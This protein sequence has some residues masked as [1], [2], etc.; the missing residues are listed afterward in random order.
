MQE[1]SIRWKQPAVPRH[2]VQAFIVD[3]NENLLLM[4]R[5][6]KVKSAKNVWSIP[7]GTHE[8]GESAPACL[9]REIKEEFDLEVKYTYLIDQ[10]ENIAGDISW[11]PFNDSDKQATDFLHV[12]VKEDP[13]HSTNEYKYGK[14]LYRQTE[15][16]WGITFNNAEDVTLHTIDNF[17]VQNE[18]YHWVLSLF[19]C[20]VPDVN[21]FT[22]MEPELHDIV[23]IISVGDLTSPTFRTDY[24]MHSSLAD[25]IERN[26]ANYRDTIYH[27]LERNVLV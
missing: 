13:K 7:T 8:L 3:H 24:P 23:K 1:P 12:R 17:E 21:A 20:V 2:V 16:L 9:F 6:D 10:Y 5:S 18:Q 25:T 14:L 22:N 15:E 4:H 26:A 11:R 27:L 19:M